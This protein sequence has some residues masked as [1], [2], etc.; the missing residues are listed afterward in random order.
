FAANNASST[1]AIKAIRD[2]NLRIGEDISLIGFDEN[3]LAQFVQ[4]RV[5]VVSRP[6]REMGIQA[7]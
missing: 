4:P 7:A 5:T 6:T 1:G 2:L 3:E